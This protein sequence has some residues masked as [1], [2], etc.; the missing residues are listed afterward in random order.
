MKVYVAKIMI[1]GTNYSTC[2]VKLSADL[3]D[4]KKYVQ[5]LVDAYVD[6][7]ADVMEK[8]DLKCVVMNDGIGTKSTITIETHEI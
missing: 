2:K 3:G 6:T 1:E 7:G 4:L 8:T 5:G